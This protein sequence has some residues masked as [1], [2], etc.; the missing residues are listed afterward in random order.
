[1]NEFQALADDFV[2]ECLPLVDEL[3]A[4]LLSMEEGTSDKAFQEP[5]L[6]GML[7]PLHTLKGNSGMMGFVPIQTLTHQVEDAVKTVMKAP[8]AVSIDFFTVFYKV[9]DSLRSMIS[10]VSKEENPQFPDI[11]DLVATLGILSEEGESDASPKVPPSSVPIVEEEASLR[12]P[13]ESLPDA[14]TAATESLVQKY[15]LTTSNSIRVDFTKLDNILDLMGELIIFQNSLHESTRVLMDELPDNENVH[16]LIRTSELYSTVVN[17]LHGYAMEIRMLEVSTVFYRF[18][19]MVRDMSQELKK[20]VELVLEGQETEV[21]KSVIDALGEPLLHLVRNAVDHGIETS[22]ERKKAGKNTRGTIKL[23]ARHEGTQVLI[24]VLDDGCGLDHDALRNKAKSLGLYRDSM[25]INELEELI[26][27][28]EFT[29]STKITTVSGRGVGLDIV[30]NA[31]TRLGGSISVTSKKGKGTLFQMALPLTL[32]SAKVLLFE[33][34]DELYAVPVSDV[35][36]SRRVG[37]KDIHQIN[38]K[39][40]IQ[41]RDQTVF[42]MDLWKHFNIK[43][44]T[45]L[46]AYMVIVH[47]K[48]RYEAFCV[49]GLRNQQD[50]VLKALDDVLFSPEGISGAT[51]LGNGRVVL[52]LDIPAMVNRNL[53]KEVS[54]NISV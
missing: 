22:G 27:L 53:G 34:G 18:S 14:L 52:I 12:L 48:N 47:H 2:K 9:I 35:I 29:T 10:L 51:I 32:A 28:P 37:E 3:E 49:D 13:S 36:E 17:Q 39:G 24:S 50:V 5:Y 31:V 33:L 19:R 23:S 38:Q 25:S 6:R 15:S 4:L 1:M 7:S 26:F 44:R 30:K 8:G 54:Q 11:D 46:G 20:D 45:E 16:T 40:I 21:D 43:R 41:W 42:V